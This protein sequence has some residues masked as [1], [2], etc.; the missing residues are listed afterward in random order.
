MF[1]IL[2]FCILQVSDSFA[3]RSGYLRYILYRVFVITSD[4][5]RKI[6]Q[7]VSLGMASTDIPS[8]YALVHITV[9]HRI[10]WRHGINWYANYKRRVCKHTLLFAGNI[11]QSW[12][13]YFRLQHTYHTLQSNLLYSCPILT[14]HHVRV[15]INVGKEAIT[16]LYKY[17]YLL[18]HK[19]G[20]IWWLVAGN[21]GHQ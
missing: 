19:D 15:S 10:I 9:L 5:K 3:W 4:F 21:T 1:P 11:H 18:S 7:F 17:R 12:R 6:W 20:S 8:K 16:F 14:W 2:I 13:Q